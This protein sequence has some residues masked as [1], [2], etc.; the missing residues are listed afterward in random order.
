V[1]SSE[2]VNIHFPSLWK[3]KLVTFEVWPSKLIT[4]EDG[5]GQKG[6]DEQTKAKEGRT[7]LGLF[8]LISKNRT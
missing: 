5:G 6:E 1:P 4:F 2:P 7:A 3:P 8:E